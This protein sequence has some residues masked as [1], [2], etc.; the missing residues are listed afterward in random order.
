[1]KTQ[2]NKRP[3]RRKTDNAGIDARA[4]LSLWR[5]VW[6]SPVKGLHVSGSVTADPSRGDI[7]ECMTYVVTNS[8]RKR[9]SSK[10]YTGE[11]KKKRFTT[12]GAAHV[13]LCELAGVRPHRD[14]IAKPLPTAEHLKDT[15]RGKTVVVPA[16]KPRIPKERSTKPRSLNTFEHDAMRNM[17]PLEALMIGA[18]SSLDNAELRI[19]FNP[20][21]KKYSARMYSR[22]VTKTGHGSGDSPWEAIEASIRDRQERQK[23]RR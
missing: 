4:Y 22:N 19:R 18:L 13:A 23:V 12:P 17:G 1:M 3:W 5:E 15:L 6:P 10:K 11:I 16:K 9:G 7:Q 20:T 8:N 21:A 2:A 14:C